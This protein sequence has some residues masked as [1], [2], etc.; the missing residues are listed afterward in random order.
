MA[1]SSQFLRA[2][3]G[4]F[5][6]SETQ[7]II[8]SMPQDLSSR[9]GEPTSKV[10]PKAFVFSPTKLLRTIHPSWH[11]EILSV[12]PE[13]CRPAL[14]RCLLDSTKQK[15]EISLSPFN[16]FLLG[17][18]IALWPESHTPGVEFVE[19][20]SLRWLMDA[21]IE[22]CI[23]LM[24]VYEIADGVHKTVEKK[25]LQQVWTRLSS[26]QQRFLRTVQTTYIP[27][28]ISLA[29][30]LKQTPDEGGRLL[31]QKG[32]QRLGWALRGEPPI[33]LWHIFHRM[34]RAQAM[35]VKDSM[36]AAPKKDE[37]AAKK[38]LQSIYQFLQRA[39]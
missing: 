37:E 7:K 1:E 35:V 5:P 9:F 23:D 26:L 11:Q 3:I 12:C 24:A 22:S 20:T 33:F 25:V 29:E 15:S 16:R 19:E 27:S 13:V 31:L 10:S 34:E 21:S 4:A 38:Q 6:H 36:E 18:F 2:L 39:K 14:E 8:R 28:K 17:Y 30:F 32:L